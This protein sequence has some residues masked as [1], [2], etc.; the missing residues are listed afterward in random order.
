MN[1]REHRERESQNRAL[2]ALGFTSEECASLRRA[3]NA[4]RRWHEMECN[5]EIQ[6]DGADGEGK[7]RRFYE[8]R[9][10]VFRS[11]L[12]CADRERGAIERI[13]NIV[14]SSNSRRG[15]PRD[16]G[17]KFFIQRDPRGAALYIIRP[18]DVPEGQTVNSCYTNG[19]CV[20]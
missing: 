18:G 1:I 2:M 3:S 10:G 19:I 20:Y 7:P 15:I 16:K 8:T 6:R 14:S 11:P 9:A 5:G 13:K 12:N 17:N 4:L